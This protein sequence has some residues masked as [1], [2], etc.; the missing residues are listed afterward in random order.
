M[1][2]SNFMSKAFSYQYLRRG[3][4][5]CTPTHPLGHAQEKIPRG[6]MTFTIYDLVMI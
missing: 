5:M 2:V 4:T 1:T 6:R 3:N